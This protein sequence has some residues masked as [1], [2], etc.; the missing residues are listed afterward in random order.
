MYLPQGNLQI[1]VGM[2]TFHPYFHCYKYPT[3]ISK[4]ATEA[5]G[6]N[7]AVFNTEHLQQH[8]PS[9]VVSRVLSCWQQ[10]HLVKFHYL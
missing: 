3:G 9:A 7:M 4:L 1:N 5:R 10:L 2:Q 6:F 8:W